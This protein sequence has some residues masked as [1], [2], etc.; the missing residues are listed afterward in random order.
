MKKLGEAVRKVHVCATCQVEK[1]FGTCP[2]CVKTAE[3]RMHQEYLRLKKDKAG[4]AQVV[5]E[6]EADPGTPIVTLI[7]RPGRNEPCPCQSGKKYKKCCGAAAA[8]IRNIEH[9]VARDRIQAEIEAQA[10]AVTKAFD[11]DT[12]QGGS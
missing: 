8:E 1:G 3:L 6:S 12:V 7:R 11:A 2:S 10:D 9:Q 4:R 5:P